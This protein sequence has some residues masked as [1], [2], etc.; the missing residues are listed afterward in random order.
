MKILLGVWN[1]N[2]VPIKK[3]N[4]QKGNHTIFLPYL[5]EG[6]KINSGDVLRSDSGKKHRCEFIQE[7]LFQNVKKWI[8]NSS[9]SMNK[10]DRSVSEEIYILDSKYAYTCNDPEGMKLSMTEWK[11]QILK[12]IK[13]NN[14]FCVNSATKSDIHHSMLKAMSKNTGLMNTV[15]TQPSS[16]LKLQLNK[17]KLFY[18][19]DFQ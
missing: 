19:T 13:D 7:K 16:I 6:C 3:G 18:F 1:S 12:A 17:N 14:L 8:E 5:Q 2:F 9:R 10:K 15:S 11:V 4:V